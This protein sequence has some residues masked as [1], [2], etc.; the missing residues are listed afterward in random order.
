MNYQKT[1]KIPSMEQ[2]GIELKDFVKGVISDIALAIQELNNDY[3][4]IG[5][6]VNPIGVHHGPSDITIAHDMRLIREVEFSLSITSS[7]AS[8]AG[9]GVKLSV[10]NAGVDNKDEKST[11]S[12]IR[13]SIPVVYPGVELP[14]RKL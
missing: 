2:L 8:N 12:I 6:A 7:N 3:A 13:F 5:L 10:L 9:G 14:H 1:N 4:G 11:A